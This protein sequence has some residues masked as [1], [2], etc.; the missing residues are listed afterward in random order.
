[1]SRRRGQPPTA[2]LAKK[3]A[4]GVACLD[5]KDE[6]EH[7]AAGHHDTCITVQ[8]SL[9]QCKLHHGWLGLKVAQH[10]D[11]HVTGAEDMPDDTHLAK[12]EQHGMQGALV[13]PDSG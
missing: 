1:M 5:G 6:S 13:Q 2:G 4:L 7:S 3:L 9:V 12:Q 8:L 11:S 10:L